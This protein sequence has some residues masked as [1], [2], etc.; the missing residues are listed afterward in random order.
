M[1]ALFRPPRDCDLPRVA[2]FKACSPRR[3]PAAPPRCLG[4]GGPGPAQLLFAGA[5][6]APSAC[7]PSQRHEISGIAL[8]GHK[9]PARSGG[10]LRRFQSVLSTDIKFNRGRDMS[11]TP[12][13]RSAPSA[14]TMATLSP[15]CRK[16]ADDADGADA[17]ATPKGSRTDSV[18]RRCHGLADLKR[19]DA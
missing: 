1:A 10:R 6:A 11:K 13:A 3:Q 7:R 2:G 19:H 17:N 14:T 12:S 9:V 4:V 18:A 15:V 8:A 16:P 5:S